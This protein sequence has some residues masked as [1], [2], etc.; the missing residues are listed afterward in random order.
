MRCPNCDSPDTFVIDTRI[1]DDDEDCG[2]HRRRQ[3]KPCGH[4]FSTW[5]TYEK[6]DMDAEKKLEKAKTA[7]EAVKKL[8]KT[9]L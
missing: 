2:R 8:L 1:L 3:C 9:A 5:E 4:K 7:I 6:P